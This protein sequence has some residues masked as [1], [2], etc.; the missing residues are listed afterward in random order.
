VIPALILAAAVVSQP[1]IVDQIDPVTDA[2]SAFLY[3]NHSETYLAVGCV[4]ITNRATMM[5][6]AKFARF[7][8]HENPSIFAGGT[9]IEYR[10]DHQPRETGRWI[11]QRYVV[12]VKGS[13]A[14]KFML[15]MRSSQQIFLRAQRPD[16]DIAQ[17]V[18]TYNNPVRLVDDV[19]ARCGYNPD[20]SPRAGV[21]RP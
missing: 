18:F 3:L 14:M 7:I 8:G 11:S 2:R 16:R 1:R 4:N 10:F 21:R 20:G 6:L 15:G 19:L 5:V 12:S 17:L 9:P 13:S